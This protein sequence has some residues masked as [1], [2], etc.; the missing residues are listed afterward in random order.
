MMNKYYYI[1]NKYGSD[2]F[3]NFIFPG[4]DPVLSKSINSIETDSNAVIIVVVISL[5]AISS[6]AILAIIK[7]KKTSN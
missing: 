7:M 5:V 2:V 4:A 6:F 3:E 1:I